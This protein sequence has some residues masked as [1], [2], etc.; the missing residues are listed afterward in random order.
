MRR[1]FLPILWVVFLVFDGMVMPGL[2]VLESGFGSI[3]FLIAL[4]LVFGIHRWVVGWGLGIGLISELLFG[5]HLGSIMGAWI[6]VVWSWYVL[7][8][9][10]TVKP[11]EEHDSWFGAIPSIVFGI[12][13][14]VISQ[15]GEW[16]I[17]RLA[18]ERTLPLELIK[19][20]LRSPQIFLSVALELGILLIALRSLYTR[21]EI[22]YG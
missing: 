22:H 9:F 10:F 18:Y 3:I 20:I 19:Y 17:I 14:F 7:N 11:L 1:F 2:R 5:L 4:L 12:L 8:R 6:I 13:L 15:G 16:L 21:R